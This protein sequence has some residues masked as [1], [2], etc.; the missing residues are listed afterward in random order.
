MK[1][2]V[3][4]SAILLSVCTFVASA[5]TQ[6]NAESP[7]TENVIQE[8]TEIKPE[9]LPDAVKKTLAGDAYKGW[10]I[11]KAYVAKEVYE[12]ELKKGADTKTFKFDK[13]GNSI[14]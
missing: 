13:E 10:E 1:K 8:K 6:P 2:Q 12:V 11:S 3:I 4:F 9:N 7:K 5:Q 14:K